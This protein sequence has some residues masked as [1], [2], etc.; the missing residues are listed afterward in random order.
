MD[1]EKK[2][3]KYEYDQKYFKEKYA[4]VKL[5]MPKPEAEALDA[6][7]KKHNLSRAG[8]IRQ[9]IKDKIESDE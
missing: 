7:C 3:Q 9:L 2:K 8:L 4:Q 1:E 6:Y 5:S